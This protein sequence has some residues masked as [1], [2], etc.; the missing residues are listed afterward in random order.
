MQL[1]TGIGAYLA[2]LL[3]QSSMSK[4]HY[5]LTCNEFN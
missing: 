3:H 4:S 1:T 5:V 2:I